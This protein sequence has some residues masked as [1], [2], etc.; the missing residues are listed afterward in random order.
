MYMNQGAQQPGTAHGRMSYSWSDGS[1]AD[2]Q[3]WAPGE[4]NGNTGELVTEMDF[5]LIGRCTGSAY[6]ATQQN[7]CETA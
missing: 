3:N 5:R 7:G 1:I 4:P 2:Y 6:A